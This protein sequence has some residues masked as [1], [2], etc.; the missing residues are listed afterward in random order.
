MRIRE[1]EAFLGDIESIFAFSDDDARAMRRDFHDE[2]RL[3][4]SG[5]PSSLKMLPAFVD[6]A[7][8][9]ERGR[10][11]ALD[12]GGTNFR[13]MSV[14]LEGS[15]RA[16]VESSSRFA[17][18][19]QVM[20][21]SGRGLFDFIAESIREF[22]N[23]HGLPSDGETRLGFTFSFPVKQ[24]GAARGILINW[25]KG[26]CARGVEGRDVVSLLERALK[27]AGMGKLRIAALANDTV[28]TMQARAYRDKLCDMGVIFGT[29]T[30]ACYREK[31]RRISKLR[32][33]GRGHMIVNIEW[34]NFDRLIFNPYDEKLDRSTHNRGEQR[35]EK[36]ISG[37]YLG[38]IARLVLVDMV[39]RKLI[40]RGAAYAFRR[41]RFG[42][43]DMSAVEG[44]GTRELSMT[45]AV[46]ERM[47]IG[48]STRSEREAV[49]RICR[50]VARRA[51][52]ISASAISSVVAW[53]DPRL[54]RAH[55]VAVDGALFELY[56]G[57]RG[58][59]L[60]E[61]KEIH[62]RKAGR[63]KLVLTKDG[64]GIGA[65]ITAAA[66]KVRRAKTP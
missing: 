4:L 53:S 65:A 37:M 32:P 46:L 27:R 62:G 14:L 5:K 64:S 26:F 47:G 41:G 43:S 2:M 15:G 16:R 25:T 23:E 31:L 6:C 9:R 39:R 49:R 24:T 63:I 51:A 13:V 29:G 60:K 19:A 34:G 52:E 22:L 45:R 42:A 61:L 56:P 50:I 12:L 20:K 40:L 35:M 58:R 66:A 17:I 30:N 48:K 3:G 11:V 36:M 44:D 21:G 33:R 18:P 10:F 1:I 28:G 38:E 55:S 8:G 59:I 7:T 57:F 54:S